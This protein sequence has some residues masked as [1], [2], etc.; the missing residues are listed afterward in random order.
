MSKQAPL[1]LP[2]PDPAQ[3][4]AYSH[5]QD[6]AQ[7][8]HVI[9]KTVATR[10]GLIWKHLAHCVYS[11]IPGFSKESRSSGVYWYQ[12]RSPPMVF[13]F[14]EFVPTNRFYPLIG[15]PIPKPR[16]FQRERG[17]SLRLALCPPNPD[18]ARPASVDIRLFIERALPVKSLLA[19]WSQS[20]DDLARLIQTAKS[21]VCFGDLLEEHPEPY[22]L[23]RYNLATSR[24]HRVDFVCE[25]A[26]ITEVS[27]ITTPVLALAKIYH[28][29]QGFVRGDPTRL[30]G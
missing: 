29:I 6:P 19:A 9:Q 8:M 21:K 18:L 27:S 28:A 5:I 25:L 16:Q 11:E 1:P 17:L 13:L 26:Q 4:F 20:R 24:K 15:M 12:Y 7:Q 14:V 3:D 23:D 2:F 10:M 30:S 22:A